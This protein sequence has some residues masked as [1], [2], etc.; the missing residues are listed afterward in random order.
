MTSTTTA[1]TPVLFDLRDVAYRYGRGQTALDGV[2]FTVREGERVALLGANGS[3]KSTLLKLLDGLYTPTQ[4]Q[5]RVFGEEVKNIESDTEAS[6]RFHQRIGL[7]FQD[8]DVQLFS[9]TVGEKSCTSGS[10]NTRPMRWW[11]R[12]EASV[13]LSMFF[14]SSPKTRN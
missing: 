12:C 5:F 1:G 7:V 13:S 3:G 4:G 10:W 14:T 6:H 2:S 9:P 8:P 11:N